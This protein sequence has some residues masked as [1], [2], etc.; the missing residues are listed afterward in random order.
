[1]TFHSS[2]NAL[3]RFVEA[4]APV[5]KTVLKELSVGKKSSHWMWFIF[6][7]LRALGRSPTA[8]YYGLENAAEAL[9]Y[10]QHPV[11]G[12]RLLEC[13]QLVLAH[14]GS[15]V[16]DIFGSPDDLKFRSCLTLFAQ[17]AP[18]EP[19]FGQALGC[20]FDGRPDEATLDLLRVS[21]L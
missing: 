9:A 8:K 2:G 16:H 12:Q 21:F 5:Y 6:P 15:T 4:Q 11:L 3:Q 7:Q 13:T 19:V 20:F 14:Q 17:V 10:W 18:D 1:M